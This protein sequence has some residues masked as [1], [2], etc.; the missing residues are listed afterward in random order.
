MIR[1]MVYVFL[2]L[3]LAFA[4]TA[5]FAQQDFSAD[6]VTS[7]GQRQN[8]GKMYVTKDKVRFEVPGE[9]G[10]GIVI[11]NFATKTSDVLMPDRKMY[12]EM[13]ATQQSPAAQRMWAFFRPADAADA[14]SAWEQTRP[15][16]QCRKIGSDTVNGRSTTEYE[17]KNP[18]G[19]AGNVWI[20]SAIVFPVKWEGKNSKGELQNIKTGSQ[21]SSLFEIPSDYQKFQMPAG[22][23]NMP[24]H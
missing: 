4:S 12:M 21:P 15:G 10:G 23:G 17:V 18:G 9:R 19:E 8:T 2:A 14:C 3:T 5:L 1:R 7:T 11:V 22:M 16:A 13:S 20:D 6:M 24:N